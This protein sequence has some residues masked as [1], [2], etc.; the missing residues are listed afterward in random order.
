MSTIFDYQMPSSGFH[1]QQSTFTSDLSDDDSEPLLESSCLI[2]VKEDADCV[3]LTLDLPGVSGKDISISIEDR[4][5]LIIKG[6]RCVKDTDGRVRKRQR[7][8]RRFRIDTSLV[9]I[10][11]AIANVWNGVLSLY[12]PK[13]KEHRTINIP[14]IEVPDFPTISARKFEKRSSGQSPRAVH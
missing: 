6:F 3:L 5:T 7:L 14:V 11:R 13:K 1:R 4:H 12:A 2:D 9:D 8:S 10:S